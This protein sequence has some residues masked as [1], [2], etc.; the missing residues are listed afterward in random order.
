VEPSNGEGQ[1]LQYSPESLMIMNWDNLTYAILAILGIAL[2][3]S[4]LIPALTSNP[5]DKTMTYVGGAL[6]FVGFYCLNTMKKKDE[7]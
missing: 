5:Q 1:D 7:D 3:L 2:G 4:W 6:M